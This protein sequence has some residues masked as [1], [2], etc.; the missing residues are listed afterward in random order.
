MQEKQSSIL[1]SYKE[2]RGKC[3]WPNPPDFVRLSCSEDGQVYQRWAYSQVQ[4]LA[5][6]GL[7]F[8]VL[9]S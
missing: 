6:A 5:V 7:A 9:F 2:I 8:E 3:L 4:L 1:L